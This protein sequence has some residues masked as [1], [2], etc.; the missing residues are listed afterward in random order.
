MPSARGTVAATFRLVSTEVPT[1]ESLGLPQS[2][3][4]LYQKNSGLV[5]VTG[6]TGKR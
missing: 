5:L 3:I 6:P 4:D 1:P 2:V